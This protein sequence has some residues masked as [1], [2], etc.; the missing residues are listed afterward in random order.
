MPFELPRTY[1]EGMEEIVKWANSL[2]PETSKRFMLDIYKIY[3]DWK[4][5]LDATPVEEINAGS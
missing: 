2:D 3:I 1:I 4:Y 5:L